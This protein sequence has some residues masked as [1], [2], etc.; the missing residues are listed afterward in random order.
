MKMTVANAI[1]KY[2]EIEGIEYAFGISGSHFIAFFRAL[3]NSSIKYISVKHETT[4]GFMALN[5]TK[6]SQKPALLLGTAGAGAMN[7]LNGVAEL[8]KSGLPAII[9]TPMVASNS[10]GKN[11]LQ[12]DTGWGNV[13]N[14]NDIMKSITRKS[15]L[16][17]IPE[18]IP[19]LMCELFRFA[20]SEHYGPV[21]LAI[22]SDYFEKEIEFEL[23]KPEQYRIVDHKAIELAKLNFVAEKLGNANE[24]VV[25]I[26]KRCIYPDTRKEID[27]LSGNFNIPIIATMNSK[28][29]FNENSPLFGGILDSFGHRS[30]DK[31]LKTADLVIS[32]GVDFHEYTTRRYDPELFT[33]AY[34]ISLDS[35]YR[36]I[37]RNYRV[38]AS[39]TGSIK[40]SLK[41][42]NRLLTDKKYHSPINPELFNKKV[43]ELN[44]FFYIQ[45]QDDT[46]PLR[47]QAVLFEI[48]RHIPQHSIVVNDIGTTCFWSL[49]NFNVYDFSYF[50]SLSG[51]SMGQGVAGCIGAKLARPEQAVFC[52]CGDG[53]MLMHGMEITTAKQYNLGLVWIVFIDGKYNM[54]DFAQKILYGDIEYCTD[55]FLPDFSKLAEAFSISCYEINKRE[56]IGA[57]IKQTALDS[58]KGLSS[59]IIVHYDKN[60]PLPVKPHVVKMM[61][62]LSDVAQYKPTGFFMKN[63]KNTLQEKT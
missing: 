35:D 11:G 47:P 49:R 45:Q 24:P 27:E 22:P 42:L 4:A 28:G 32:C 1:I 44:D 43:K 36:E 3:K 58:Q 53:A 31:I 48:S 16:A 20:L 17:H 29:L 9:I 33:N 26:G 2:L 12:E 13:Y 38:D 54:V 25:L 5:Y 60:E 63:L 61:E 14:I 6:A 15:L 51:A 52:I 10:F 39:L 50:V 62:D 30:A 41:Y 59:L 40:E 57:I 34:H 56:E 21:H 37:G 19:S 23:Y 18:I 46:T 55:I 8:Y 7:L